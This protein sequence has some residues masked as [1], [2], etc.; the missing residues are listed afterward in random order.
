MLMRKH[1]SGGR[2]TDI[3]QRE[4]ER[5]IE[6]D[7]ETMNELGF[8]VNKRLIFEIMGKHSN[9]IALDI[10]T[11]KIIDCIKRISI[12]VNRVRQLLPGKI[13]EYPPSQG[14]IPLDEITEASFADID[15]LFAV[16]MDFGKASAGSPYSSTAA[17]AIDENALAKAILGKVQGISPA[18][19][20]NIAENALADF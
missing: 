18:V 13:Y 1:F 19:A 15:K 9:I 7:V 20:N 6:I 2:I 16:P 10:K 4:T 12:D 5:I 14:K 11:G 3:R 8:S 17:P